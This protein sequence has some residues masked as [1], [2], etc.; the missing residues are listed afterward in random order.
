V[1]LSAHTLELDAAILAEENSPSGVSTSCTAL[2]T[3]GRSG[4]GE[5]GQDRDVV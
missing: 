3:L 1:V 4:I 5:V 2:R